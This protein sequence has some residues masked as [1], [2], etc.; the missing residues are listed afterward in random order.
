MD[1]KTTLSHCATLLEPANI[2]KEIIGEYAKNIVQCSIINPN[3][4]QFSEKYM[5]RDKF[6]NSLRISD[7]IKPNKHVAPNKYIFTLGADKCHVISEIYL[8]IKSIN[9][10]ETESVISVTFNNTTLF[11]FNLQDIQHILKMY[12]NE[13]AKFKDYSCIIQKKSS[14]PCK[15]YCVPIHTILNFTHLPLFENSLEIKLSNIIIKD[16]PEVHYVGH[17]LTE[18]EKNRFNDVGNERTLYQFKK[19]KIPS[20]C[21]CSLK[22]ANMIIDTIIAVTDEYVTD[23]LL[24]YKSHLIH[25]CSTSS[26]HNIIYNEC[27]YDDGDNIYYYQ[28]GNTDIFYSHGKIFPDESTEIQC[29]A[30][31]AKDDTVLFLRY[32]NMLQITATHANFVFD[33]AQD[34]H[35]LYFD[36]YV[37]EAANNSDT[38]IDEKFNSYPLSL[39]KDGTYVEGYWFSQ[40]CS[41]KSY[42]IPQISSEPNSNLFLEKMKQYIKDKKPFA[43][44]FG[45][46]ECRLCGVNNGSSEYK[47]C[48]DDM[49]IYFPEGLLHYY[50]KHNVHPSKEFY[51][52]I[53]KL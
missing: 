27:G 13:Y 12:P 42:P 38:V 41:N 35:I 47:I 40:L 18:I 28:T 4:T 49:T 25:L 44:Y 19:L 24:K 3:M 32:T 53:M 10:C 6:T 15:L 45:Q 33:P 50:E 31:C 8:Y 16:I 39:Q 9:K 30:N 23:V 46:S 48:N 22:S 36:K 37:K 51:A 5:A 21:W 1:S 17:I 20:N 11:D 34:E 29:V 52:A 14:L 43:Q 26:M 2:E 7:T